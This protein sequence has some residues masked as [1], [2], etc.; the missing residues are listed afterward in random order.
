MRR[1]NKR[2]SGTKAESLRLHFD[3]RCMERLGRVLDHK[4]LVQDISQGNMK[5]MM[6]QSNRVS[7]FILDI[8][9]VVY[10]LFYDKSRQTCITIIPNSWFTEEAQ[11]P[12][13]KSLKANEKDAIDLT[14]MIMQKYDL[15]WEQARIFLES[16]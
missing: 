8:D 11:L 4:Q 1:K 9:E 3:R 12:H 2:T 14:Q 5:F 7:V 6:K 13:L 10:R 15:N 16:L